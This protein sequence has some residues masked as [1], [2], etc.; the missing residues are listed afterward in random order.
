MFQPD[1]SELA[2][3]AGFFDGE[4]HSGIR[5]FPCPTVS[6]SQTEPSTL[7]RFQAAVGGIGVIRG[8][9]DK[10]KLRPNHSPLWQYT[11]NVRDAQAVIAMLWPFLSKPKREQACR[12]F[13]LRKHYAEGTLPRCERGHQVNPDDERGCGLCIKRQQRASRHYNHTIQVSAAGGPATPAG[14]P[15]SAAG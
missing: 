15:I 11:T 12:V 3:A 1:R 2:W 6:I 5:T 10:S 9:Y 4:G 7:E 8:P 13:E 14:L